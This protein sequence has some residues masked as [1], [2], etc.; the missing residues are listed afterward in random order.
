[1]DGW[2][3][4]W[5]DYTVWMY[6]TCGQVH[7]VRGLGSLA[8][9]QDALGDNGVGRG[10]G[11]GVYSRIRPTSHAALPHNTLR[12]RSQ[13]ERLAL[14]LQMARVKCEEQTQRAVHAE[15]AL[16][17]ARAAAAAVA[18]ASAPSSGNI[19][20]EVTVS[21]FASVQDGQ[22]DSGGQE[23]STVCCSVRQTAAEPPPG[24]RKSAR[25]GT[26]AGRLM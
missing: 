7:G 11:R 16:A 24:K 25:P 2:M 9:R 21:C 17:E 18:R 4:G 8:Q 26:A 22:K 10:G 19:S 3:G 20:P 15:R 23:E 13:V 5:M 1:M 12:H 6:Y 14:A